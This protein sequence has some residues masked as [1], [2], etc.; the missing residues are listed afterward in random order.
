M[1]ITIKRILSKKGEKNKLIHEEI[2]RLR[3]EGLFDDSVFWQYMKRKFRVN[4]ELI[5]LK[6]S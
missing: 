6:D 5:T 2:E 3:K 4:N 1:K